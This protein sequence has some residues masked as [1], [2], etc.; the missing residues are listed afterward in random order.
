SV[1]GGPRC[2]PALRETHAGKRSGAEWRQVM[3]NGC[4]PVAERG[5]SNS[6]DSDE[7][8]WAIRL[9]LLNRV[10]FEPGAAPQRGPAQAAE[11]V[12]VQS[13]DLRRWI[14]AGNKRAD[15]RVWGG[16]GEDAGDRGLAAGER[17]QRAADA[18]ADREFG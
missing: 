8:A 13:L 1:R 15:Q 18:A 12:K 2:G 3:F 6:A 10:L 9:L 17:L 11:G 7:V 14:F 4:A 16:A 5:N